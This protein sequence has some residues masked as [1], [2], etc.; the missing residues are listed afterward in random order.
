MASIQLAQTH[1][2][3]NDF[4]TEVDQVLAQATLK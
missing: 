3:L 4:F 2:L 1:Q